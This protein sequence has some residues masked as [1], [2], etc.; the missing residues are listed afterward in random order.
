MVSKVARQLRA[1]VVGPADSVTV[2]PAAVATL[3]G[4]PVSTADGGHEVGFVSSAAWSPALGR[5]VALATLHRRVEPPE[6][7]TVAWSVP[8]RPVHRLA[9]E[10]RILPLDVP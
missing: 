10:A 9:A 2:G 6:P 7:V 3:C 1:V 5:P 8:G 4:S